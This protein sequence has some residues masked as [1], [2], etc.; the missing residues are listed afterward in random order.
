MQ[1]TFFHYIINANA[2]EEPLECSSQNIKGI[3]ATFEKLNKLTF[4]PEVYNECALVVG[5]VVCG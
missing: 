5:G 2:I 3:H 1:R 4:L